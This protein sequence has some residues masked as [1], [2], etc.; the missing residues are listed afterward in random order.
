MIT[1]TITHGKK[2]SVCQLKAFGDDYF[3]HAQT[4]DH[5]LY[6]VDRVTA[7][8]IRKY[9]NNFCISRKIAWQVKGYQLMEIDRAFY[10][11]SKISGLPVRKQYEILSRNF[12][13]FTSILPPKHNKS[14]DTLKYILVHI[15]Q[16]LSNSYSVDPNI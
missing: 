9:L 4:P 3:I 13:I 16:Y 11:L 15:N 10:I 1:R 12:E 5:L 2:E 14:H 8:S 6:K 7:L